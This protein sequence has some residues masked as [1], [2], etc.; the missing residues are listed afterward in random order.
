ML[1]AWYVLGGPLVSFCFYWSIQ[2]RFVFLLFSFPF[3]VSGV[4]RVQKHTFV[5]LYG[6]VDIFSTFIWYCWFLFFCMFELFG[7]LWCVHLIAFFALFL[8]VS[9][10]CIARA[11]AARIAGWSLKCSAHTHTFTESCTHSHWTDGRN[12][13]YF[14]TKYV[15]LWWRFVEDLYTLRDNFPVNKDV[16]R[17]FLH[18][19][20]LSFE[21]SKYTLGSVV[22]RTPTQSSL[23]FI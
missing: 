23:K 21:P 12:Q 15:G 22:C 17:T 7:T 18:Y 3:F 8:C 19:L 2:I 1:G 9:I 14:L 20:A 6:V 5:C 4:L 10:V 13:T 11:A 16:K